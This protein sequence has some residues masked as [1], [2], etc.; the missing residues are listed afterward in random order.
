MGMLAWLAVQVASTPLALAEEPDL[1]SAKEPDP[2][3]NLAGWTPSLSLG[4]GVHVTPVEGFVVATNSAGDF[5]RPPQYDD[6]TAVTPLARISLGIETP[7]LPLIPGN[8][9]LFGSADY[10]V[11]FPP[12]L[13]V[14][15]EGNPT[16]FLVP[17]GFRDPPAAAIEGQ[18]SQTS[19]EMGRSAYGLTGGVSIPIDV[20]DFQFHIKPGVSWMRQRWE[21]KGVVLAVEKSSLPFLPPSRDF[22]GIELRARGKLYSSGVGPYIAIEAEPDSWGPILVSAFIEAAYYRTLGDRKVNISDSE[23]LTGNNLPPDTY[24]GRW[25]IEVD[26][27]FWRAGVGIRVFLAAD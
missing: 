19:L 7:E 8:I 10:F 9:R 18:G 25:G 23:T 21:V 12:S 16:G 13:K 17:P 4:L 22:R 1:A 20:G 3:W 15:N 6:N 27:Y 14:A 2:R 5:V 24:L 26:K 11:S